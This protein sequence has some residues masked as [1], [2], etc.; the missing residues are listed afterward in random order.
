[1]SFSQNDCC[2]YL[3]IS[4]STNDNPTEINEIFFWEKFF[5]LAAVIEFK[6]ILTM[7]SSRKLIKIGNK[8]EI[9]TIGKCFA[10]FPVYILVNF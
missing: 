2:Q 5:L 10:I 8:T 6:G 1:M 4:I 3:N 7:I 9:Y